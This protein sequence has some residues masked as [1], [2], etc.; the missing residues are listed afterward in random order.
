MHIIRLTNILV[1]ALAF[2]VTAAV[3]A[4]H[5]SVVVG[6]SFLAAILITTVIRWLFALNRPARRRGVRL[7]QFLSRESAPPSL[8][9]A[10][11]FL[12]GSAI[13]T[14]SR[15]CGYSYSRFEGRLRGGLAALVTLLLE[16]Q[17]IDAKAVLNQWREECSMAEGQKVV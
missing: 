15:E 16:A 11:Q 3:F 5:T 1:V 12:A 14:L 9:F 10:L 2:M 8:Q 6:A 7:D 17:E 4:G 13:A